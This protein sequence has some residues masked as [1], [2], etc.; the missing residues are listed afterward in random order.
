MLTQPGDFAR[1]QAHGTGRPD[2]LLVGRF[3]RNELGATRFAFATPG[4]LGGAV[5]RNRIRRRLREALRALL[6]GLR[7]GWDVLIIAR[8]G[9]VAADHAALA[10]SVRRVLRAGGVLEERTDR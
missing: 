10:A 2:P 3:V 9:I 4:R 5:V 1:L 7:P 8:P 6:P